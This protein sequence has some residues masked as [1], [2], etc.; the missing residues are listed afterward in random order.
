V[1]FAYGVPDPSLFPWDNFREI[2]TDIVDRHDRDALYYGNLRGYP[3]LV[4]SICRLMEQRQIAAP[5]D[6]VLVTSGSQQAIDIVARVLL[7]PG[8]VVL[9]E[10]PTYAGAITAFKL[11]SA[12]LASVRLDETGIDIDDLERV[13]QR[14]AN[15]G[16]T[17]KLLYLIPNCN[18]PT[19]ALMS[20]SKRQSV[21]EWTRARGVMVVEDDAYHTVVF[22]EEGGSEAARPI[23]AAADSEHVIYLSTFSKLLAPTFRIGW[24]VAPPPLIERFVMAKIA[25]DLATSA[26]NQRFVDE[27]LRRGVV[28]KLTPLWRDAYRRKR[29][30]M[31]AALHDQFGD[32]LV[33]WQPKGG[34]YLWVGIPQ[35]H[36]LKPSVAQCARNQGVE[37]LTGEMFCVDGS[38]QDKIR[39]AFS[40][41]PQEQIPEGIRRLAKALSSGKDDCGAR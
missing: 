13:W 41:V 12:R 30:L 4:E 7:Q 5:A 23:R 19:G 36:Q 38:G 20:P 32:A 40:A 17:I 15:C 22:D 14:S 29:D 34:F 11:S 18:N 16:G 24:I 21:L 1:S 27:M 2:V 6:H 26:L 3:P 39:L 9:I 28:T 37:I 25:M 10:S 33:W 31:E 35:G 8:D